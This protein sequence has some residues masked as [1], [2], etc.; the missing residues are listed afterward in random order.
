MYKV[1]PIQLITI[2][3]FSQVFFSCDQVDKRKSYYENGKIKSISEMKDGL[4]HGKHEF[5]YPSGNLQSRGNYFMGKANGLLEHFYESGKLESKAYW[6]N[7]KENG[8]ALVY[9]E[10]GALQFCANYKDGKIWGISKVFY[11]DGKIRER[12]LYDSLGNIIHITV[13]RSNG[14]LKNSFVVPSVSASKDTIT[15]GEEVLLK[16]KFPFKMK[17]D[18]FIQASETEAGGNVFYEPDVLKCS[19]Y[20]SVLY[21]RVFNSSGK[22]KLSFKFE[23]TN[24]DPIDTLNVKN[25]VKDYTIVVLGSSKIRKS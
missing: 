3:V 23:H 13:F 4:M 2:I 1:S 21:R 7:G 18:I 15:L 10:N 8:E 9:F 19:S 14:E 24:I 6:L 22:Y 17:G 12:K 25:V 20:D 5:Y 16:I 11:Q